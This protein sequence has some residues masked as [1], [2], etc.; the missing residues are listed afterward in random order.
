M[1]D[2]LD[3]AARVTAGVEL[4][5]GRHAALVVDVDGEGGAA[6]AIVLCLPDGAPAGIVARLDVLPADMGAL[7]ATA[8]NGVLAARVDAHEIAAALQAGRARV[9]CT[10]DPWRRVISLSLL[11]PGGEWYALAAGRVP[12][13]RVH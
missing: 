6:G 11:L 10:V 2:L 12:E 9:V 7:V 13:G 3:A 4:P 5:P 1:S 8:I